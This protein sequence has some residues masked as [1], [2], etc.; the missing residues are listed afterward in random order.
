MNRQTMT[1]GAMAT[2]LAEREQLEARIEGK[3]VLYN[4]H[5]WDW[6]VTIDRWVA[7]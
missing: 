3:G 4:G 6:D 7:R 1:S 5:V 2:A